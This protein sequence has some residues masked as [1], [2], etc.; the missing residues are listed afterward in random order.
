M[1][2][3]LWMML[4][5]LSILITMVIGFGELS[6]SEIH[7]Y[8]LTLTGE[9]CVIARTVGVSVNQRD[10]LCSVNTRFLPN[11]IGSGGTI[12][13][14]DDQRLSASEAM[15]LASQKMPIDLPP[16]AGQRSNTFWA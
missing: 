5:A 8:K 7:T 6:R 3:D 1:N 16:T 2:K 14:D 10:G 9:G 4:R 12:I 11:K 15:L 13:L